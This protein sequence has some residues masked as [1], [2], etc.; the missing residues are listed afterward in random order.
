MLEG[1]IKRRKLTRR[2]FAIRETIHGQLNKTKK[3]SSQNGCRLITT[4]RGG[5]QREYN[6]TTT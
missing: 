3:C 4:V 1:L 6:P 5:R 2:K